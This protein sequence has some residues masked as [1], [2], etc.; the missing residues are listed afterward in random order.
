MSLRRRRQLLDSKRTNLDVIYCPKSSVEG[1]DSR[2]LF[3]VLQVDQSKLSPARLSRKKASSL[4]FGLASVERTCKQWCDT[5]P[6]PHAETR[7]TALW[8][9]S[10][11]TLLIYIHFGEPACHNMYQPLCR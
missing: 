2:P 1:Q 4:W 5:L 8:I 10:P 6:L 7:K 3:L 11:E 9:Y